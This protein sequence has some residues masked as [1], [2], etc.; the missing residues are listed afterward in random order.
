MA[1]AA[2]PA[3]PAA[4]AA[5][6]TRTTWRRPTW[7]PPPSSTCPRAAARCHRTCPPSRKTCAPRGYAHLPGGQAGP[8]HPRVPLAPQDTGQKLTAQLWDQVPGTRSGGARRPRCR[9]PWPSPCK[10]QAVSV[11]RG[12]GTL[13]TQHAL[14]F[15]I[16][17]RLS[18]ARQACALAVL[19]AGHPELGTRRVQ[20]RCPG[21]S[22]TGQ[23]L[24]AAQKPV[25]VLFP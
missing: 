11:S 3:A 4:R 1:A 13:R 8:V 10:T 5:S 15:Q 23:P 17:G 25:L 2:A 24:V 9:M 21:A 22:L 18:A 16:Q 14:N 12:T 6:T 7:R 20:I 19:P